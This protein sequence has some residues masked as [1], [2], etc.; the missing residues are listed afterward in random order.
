MKFLRHNIFVGRPPQLVCVPTNVE[1]P[2][3]DLYHHHFQRSNLFLFCRHTGIK[4]GVNPAFKVALSEGED[5]S[6]GLHI[7]ERHLALLVIHKH[8]HPL[9]RGRQR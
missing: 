1:T 7:E 9:G 4:Y 5:V 2:A 6:V 3:L 8:P